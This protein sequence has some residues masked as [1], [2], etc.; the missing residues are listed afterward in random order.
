M[1]TFCV[2]RANNEG[3]LV[4]Y[5][6]DKPTKD[7]YSRAMIRI[8]DSSH[9]DYELI[10]SASW[11]YS[12][13]TNSLH[14]P[15]GNIF[16]VGSKLEILEMVNFFKDL[17]EAITSLFDPNQ[18]TSARINDLIAKLTR[19]Q[20][21]KIQNYKNKELKEMNSEKHG[22]KIKSGKLEKKNKRYEEALRSV[23]LIIEQEHPLNKRFRN[24]VEKAIRDSNIANYQVCKDIL[25]ILNSKY[26]IPKKQAILNK[27]NSVVK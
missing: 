22:S 4:S 3:N 7:D 24:Q 1:T 2:L 10:N 13:E 26:P 23:R 20:H 8:N 15:K 17:N 11:I 18:E 5:K 27:I 19:K 12:N 9:E 16:K 25:E 21:S 6:T 14:D